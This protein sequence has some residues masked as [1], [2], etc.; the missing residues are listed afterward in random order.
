MVRA[1]LPQGIIT[2][3]FPQGPFRKIIFW[4]DNLI[5]KIIDNLGNFLVF[6]GK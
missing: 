2:N 6:G 3:H 1:Y 4:I 5:N